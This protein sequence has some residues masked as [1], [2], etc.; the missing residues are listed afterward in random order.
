MLRCLDTRLEVFAFGK[1]H[2]PEEIARLTAAGT[3]L[4]ELQAAY[5]V[6]WQRLLRQLKTR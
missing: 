4:R 6:S 3:R 2:R 5:P 1:T